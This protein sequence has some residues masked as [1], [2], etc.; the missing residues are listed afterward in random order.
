MNHSAG[1]GP[2]V[3]GSSPGKGRPAWRTINITPAELL[4]RIAVGL[5]AIVAGI[6][7]LTSAGSVLAAV[8]EALLTAAGLDLAVT[9]AV[10]HCPLYHK[11][12]YLP[13]PL[14]G[15]R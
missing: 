9:G 11:L 12:G 10:G 5:A 7:L 6:V 3:L 13:K 2:V 1:P 4:G 14:R 15:T 8:L